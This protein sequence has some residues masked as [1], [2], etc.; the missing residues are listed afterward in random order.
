VQCCRRA[1]VP[2]P[3]S[4]ARS[5]AR[6]TAVDALRGLVIAIMALD[7]TRDFFHAA[8]M[9][10]APD[11]LATTTAPVFLTRWVTHLCAPTFFLTAGMAARLR[12]ERPGAT[13]GE[14]SRF[15]W[16]RGLWL[17]AV[18]LIV[19]RFAMNFTFDG[20]YPVLL[21]ILWA[22]GWSMVALAALVRLPVAALGVVA[23][24]I[25][26]L[27]NLLDP[28][29]ARQLGGL[30]WLWT[31]L[32]APGAI[33]T[34]GPVFVAGY[35][36]LPWIGVMAAGYVAGGVFSWPAADRQR[37]LVRAGTGALAA[38][39]VVRW[40]NG[41]G[42][43]RPWAA[44]ATPLFTVLSFLDTSKY[45]PSLAFVLMTLGPALLL[46]VWLER[47]P[48]GPRHPFVVFGRTPFAF[49]VLHF[50]LLHALASAAA[51]ARYG[52]ASLA[53]LAHP[54]PSMGGPAA[55]FPA[56]FGYGLAVVYAVWLAVLALMWPLCAWLGRVKAR[57]RDW[58]L[59]YL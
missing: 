34:G 31:I 46:L 23:A 21:I 26:L 15:L 22:L 4:P 51:F 6:V 58:W 10:G 50:F 52:P 25:L 7:H 59:S 38:F 45:P 14:V 39:V 41:Y 47:R 37:V 53:F 18:E 30:G 40:L 13:A 8:A 1:L 57:R 11:A 20:R 5:W 16:T 36:V 48:P 44:Q 43:P 17:I 49:Y 28:I 19:M 3:S 35:P 29:Q 42:D 24:A 33:V 32:H 56:G 2:L 27:H 9:T 12:A 55:L 54:L